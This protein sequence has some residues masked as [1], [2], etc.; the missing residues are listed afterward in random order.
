MEWQHT[1]A[2]SKIFANFIFDFTFT[3]IS[4]GYHDSVQA[5][6]IESE[7]AKKG[8]TCTIVRDIEVQFWFD[9]LKFLRHF[10]QSS[11]VR[12]IID[13]DVKSRA[14]GND[15]LESLQSVTRLVV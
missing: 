4:I 10:V 12:S 8:L 9:V 11:N 7:N 2:A 5:I 15:R 1:S 6:V 3:V 13:S 14:K